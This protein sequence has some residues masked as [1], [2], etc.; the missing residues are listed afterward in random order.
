MP[1]MRGQQIAMPDPES[2]RIMLNA[3][4]FGDNALGG[5]DEVVRPDALPFSWPEA[6]GRDAPRTLEIGFNRG[7]FLRAMADRW[8]DHDHVGIEVRRR[9]VYRFA[10]LHGQAADDGSLALKNVRVIWADAKRVTGPL[11]AAQ[12]LSAIFINFPDPWWKKRHHKRRLVQTGF[13]REMADLL[14]PGGRI[15]VKSDVLAIATEIDEVL[16]QTPGLGDR[17][18]FSADDLPFTHRETSCVRQGMPITRF[19]YGRDA[20]ADD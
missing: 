14:A 17:R 1:R 2:A 3:R 5:Y 4:L 8:P 12:K 11:F 13:A 19:S 6:F 10:H 16:G 7:R 15:W 9:Y 18:A 20:V